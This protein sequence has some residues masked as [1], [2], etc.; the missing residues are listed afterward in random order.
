MADHVY[1]SLRVLLQSSST[2]TEGQL[3]SVPE[4]SRELFQGSSTPS[5][6]ASVPEESTTGFTDAFGPPP[7]SYRDSIRS[8]SVV[9]SDWRIRSTFSR[10]SGSSDSGAS[11]SR[12]N[13]SGSSNSVSVGAA[14]MGTIKLTKIAQR[15][16]SDGYTERMV[17][18]F[19]TVSLAQTF[20]KDPSLRNWFA[21]LDVDWVLDICLQLHLQ[22]AS[23]YSLQELV[24]RWIRA[25]TIIIATL[26]TK[27]WS[28]V[29][30]VSN[31]PAATRF[32]TVSVSTMLVFVVAI[33]QDL[34]VNREKLLAMLQMYICLC[35]ASDAMSTTGP[36][37]RPGKRGA[38]PG[39]PAP[40]CCLAPGPRISMG[41]PWSTMH[42]VSNW[43]AQSIFKE[44]GDTL[45]GEVGKLMESIC[46]TM[47][48]LLRWTL[49][50]DINSWA[51]EILG[52][53]GEVHKNI[54]LMVDYVV[55]MRK[56]R[57]WTQLNTTHRHS[58]ENFEDMINHATNYLE[59]LLRKSELCSDP[60]LRYL[61]LLNNS[62]FIGDVVSEKPVSFNPELWR[63]HQSGL[64]LTPE[65]EKY[66]D[67]YLDVS[68][69]RVVSYIPKSNFHGPLRRWINT[70]S[71]AKF[72]SAFDNTY[73]AQKF[74][75]VPEP[76]LRSL[77]Q[78]TIIKRVISAYN[79]Y[80][81]EHPEL[82]KSVSGR[83]NCPKVMEEMLGDL[84]EG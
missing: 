3:A 56:A 18:A 84:F 61:F 17:Q 38:R 82:E 32:A 73:Q 25:L 19:H 81:K 6:L 69:E 60:S 71:L 5:R 63:G 79:N 4:E 7:N 35:S 70:T 64:K 12:S 65:C 45:E 74:W 37:H 2:D 47:K 29:T 33:I 26:S 15:M 62:Y 39:P 52:G 31:T 1:T 59:N 67:S 50:E 14:D 11:R 28:Q 27:S 42:A 78:E 51:T 83:S 44:I 49:M 80:L 58:T 9:C 40:S 8:V 48:L 72:H 53:G 20:G 23:T 24:E 68:W 16:I 55:L 41:R 43:D 22:E 10:Q 57:A 21:E 77:L 75:K 54:R 36:A 66:L 46:K 76:R 13:T 30:T 34:Q